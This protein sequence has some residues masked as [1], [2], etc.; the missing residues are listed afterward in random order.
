MSSSTGGGDKGGGHQRPHGPDLSNVPIGVP[1]IPGVKPRS[2][3]ITAGGPAPQH[4]TTSVASLVPSTSSVQRASSSPDNEESYEDAWARAEREP[5]V[6]VGDNTTIGTE[7]EQVLG[8]FFRLK[9]REDPKKPLCRYS[10]DLGPDVTRSSDPKSTKP[11]KLS[12]E[13]KRFLICDYDSIII[14]AG[15]LFSVG[16]APQPAPYQRKSGKDTWH[17]ESGSI[18]FDGVV[19]IGELNRHIYKKDGGVPTSATAIALNALNIIFG[20]CVNKPD[21]DGARAGK[22]FYPPIPGNPTQTKSGCYLI[23]RGFFSS[24]RPGTGSLYLNVSTT[25]SA[26]FKEMNLL[27]WMKMKWGNRY[28][29]AKFRRELNNVRVKCDFT[30][31]KRWTMH[32]ELNTKKMSAITLGQT[33]VSDHMKSGKF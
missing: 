30:E 24:V 7:G 11:R 2:S 5:P 4:P 33:N 3:A 12:R 14:S 22:R 13:T 8:N 20:N 21:F 19:E 32:G 28:N 17:T 29:E 16:S 18:K 1:T 10:I 31:E 25:T 23:H 27:E 9:I 6:R 26:F 15:R